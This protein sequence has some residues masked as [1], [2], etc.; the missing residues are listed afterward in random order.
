MSIIDSQSPVPAYDI[1]TNLDKAGL[2]YRLSTALDRWSHLWPASPNA[3]ILIKPNLNSNMN[4]L[5]GNTTDLRLIHAIILYFS[6]KGYQN[7]IIGEGTN[8]GFYRRK[9]NVISRLGVDRLAA[10]HGIVV[11]DLNQSQPLPI[12]FADDITAE[13]AEECLTADLFINLPKLKTHAETGMSVCLKNLMGCLVGQKNKKKTHQKLAD[14]ILH[15]NQ[16]VKPHLH[17]IDALIAMEGLGPTRGHPRRLDTI[18][19]GDNPLFLDLLCSALTS[20]PKTEISPLSKARSLN[21]IPLHWDKEVTK[22]ANNINWKPFKKARPGWLAAFINHPQRQKYFLLLRKNI[23]ISRL[24]DYKWFGCLLFQLGLR[25]DIFEDCELQL[26]GLKFNH[27]LCNHC[28][29]CREVCP[30]NLDLPDILPQPGKNCIGCLYCLASCPQQA[31]QMEGKAGFYA[32]QIKQYDTLI[33]KIYVN[34]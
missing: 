14:N 12:K 31:Y 28:G 29:I 10:W 19:I 34:K 17:I 18:I 30:I 25:Q 24:L 22:S 11:K 4:A 13:V 6:S 2:N 16:Q 32:E 26:H 7:I 23:V 1:L 3:L 5:T 15:L 8:S 33:R 9:I 21:K 27:E 20:I